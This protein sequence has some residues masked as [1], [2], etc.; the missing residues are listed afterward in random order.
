MFLIEFHLL[1]WLLELWK[2]KKSSS[3]LFFCIKLF[4]PLSLLLEGVFLC[5]ATCCAF[6]H[7]TTRRGNHKNAFRIRLEKKE[8][9]KQF[10]ILKKKFNLETMTDFY[11]EKKHYKKI[12]NRNRRGICRCYVGLTLTKELFFHTL[13]IRE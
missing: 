4:F 10:R 7:L 1:D 5:P 6:Q 11:I 12:C 8:L 13:R 2:W 9:E 3:L